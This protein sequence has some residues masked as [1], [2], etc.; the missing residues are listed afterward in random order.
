MANVKI[1][2]LPLITGITINDVIPIVDV[3]TLV[4]S[5]VTIGDLKNYLDT[6][7]TGGTVS[8]ETTFINGLSATT[9]SATTIDLCSTS[10]T[11]FTSSIS[12]CSP[13]EFLSES[14][15]TKGLSALTLSSST[16][17]V[18]GQ[19]LE[20]FTGGTVSGNT[21]FTNGLTANTISA[22][23]Y[24][25]LP[26]D[27]YVTGGTYSNGDITFTNNTGGT[28]NVNGLFTG[29]TDVYV[30]GGTYSNGDLTL[31]NN[32]GGTFNVS[33]FYT[34][35]TDVFVT[36]GT[37]NNNTF[38]YTNN[39][40]GTFDVSFNSVSGLTSNGTIE[41]NVISATTISGGTLYGD[42]SNLSGISQTPFY[43]ESIWTSFQTS[44][45]TTS[46]TNYGSGGAMAV[47]FYVN[48]TVTILN[49]SIECSL[50][51]VNPT[52]CEF[53]IYDVISGTV[54]NRLYHQTFQITGTGIV[55][56]SSV[57][58]TLQPGIYAYATTQDII[59]GWRSFTL[60]NSVLG[61]NSS[62]GTDTFISAK[63]QASNNL[64]NPFG[65]QTN[66]NS[67]CPL[68]IFEIQI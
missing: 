37:Y 6:S 62:M 53:A 2:D 7:F 17:Y 59:L 11:L 64:L 44:V 20:S 68:A 5:K 36:G 66:N 65:S 50:I 18:D 33:G 3:D 40:G 35:G 46:S 61:V 28:F 4:T 52:N 45:R 15:F 24:F 27:V 60:P 48:K 47:P 19:I 42:G 57:N 56:F 14:F 63:T 8:G 23:T 34:G 22:T 31:V 49:C 67:N 25:G 10:G 21:E 30:T 51:A 16:I 55:T 43:Q 29:S 26:T 13:I 39:T 12:G 41:S 32:T 54:T 38:T 9:F 1:T 58:L